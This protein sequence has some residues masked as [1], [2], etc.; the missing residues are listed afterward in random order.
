MLAWYSSWP[1]ESPSCGVGD[2]VDPHSTADGWVG[3]LARA[4]LVPK[5]AGR[6][7]TANISRALFG[8]GMGHDEHPSTNCVLQNP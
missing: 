1:R 3:A 7:A 6:D 2:R 8:A 4:T 5:W